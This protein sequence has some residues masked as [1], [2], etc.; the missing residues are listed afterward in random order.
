MQTMCLTFNV[1]KRKYAYNFYMNIFCHHSTYLQFYTYKRATDKR[2][3]T[4][5]WTRA[6]H[7]TFKWNQRFAAAKNVFFFNSLLLKILHGII[8]LPIIMIIITRWNICC[9]RFSVKSSS[10]RSID[11]YFC[12]FKK[13]PLLYRFCIQMDPKDFYKN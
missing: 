13:K 7:K 12:L 10:V 5:D 8:C 2:T 11:V 4:F 3:I 9:I 1:S 6:W